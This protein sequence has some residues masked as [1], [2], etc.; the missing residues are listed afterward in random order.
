MLFNKEN[1]GGEEL[2]SLLGFI[3]S[4]TNF[5][6]WITWINLSTRQVRG[7]VGSELIERADDYYHSDEFDNEGDTV[8][9]LLVQKLQLTVALFA[10]VKLIPSIDAGHGNSGRRKILGETEKG[11]TAEEAYKDEANI[12]NLAYEALEDLILFCEENEIEEWQS[13]AYY[14][15]SK[16]LLI[17]T[18]AEFDL[19]YKINSSR[20]FFTLVPIMSEIEELHLV[21]ILTKDRFQKMKDALSK[22][23]SELDD[24]EKKLL[25]L[26]SYARRAVALL[27]MATA[28][29]RLPIEV[30]PEG[31]VQ[32]QV[33]GTVKERKIASENVRKNVAATLKVDGTKWLDTLE[34]A[35]SSLFDNNFDV[36][37]IIVKPISNDKIKGFIF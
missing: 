28:L 4:T 18:A 12:L 3:D 35:Y 17:N 32:V 6:K 31:L 24:E 30:L 36:D 22:A 19:Y 11:L 14:S 21:S 15:L 26:V 33:V 25:S 13:S 7:L 8:D 29:E 27:T 20:L 5:K 2:R 37:K 10:Y 16:S 34:T 9:D 1:V 23:T